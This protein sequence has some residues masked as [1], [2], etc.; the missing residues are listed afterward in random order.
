M[1]VLLAMVFAAALSAG[2]A[3]FDRTAAEGAAKIAMARFGKSLAENGAAAGVL[4]DAMLADPGRFAKKS[5][6]ES[7][8]LPMYVKSAEDA[9]AAE[10]SD[11][12]R[13]L[14][15]PDDFRVELSERDRRGVE[16]RFRRAFDEE[17]REAVAA[18][19]RGIVAATR[20][21]EE[22]FES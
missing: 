9:Y 20:P 10:M 6:A 5:A 4:K 2:N 19:A 13:R 12:A 14:S 21:G 7:E 16:E 11:V 3:E 18:Q 1:T 17:R 22:E 8:C 15:L